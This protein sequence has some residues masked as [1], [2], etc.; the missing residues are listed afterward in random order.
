MKNGRDT[1]ACQGALIW[2]GQDVQAGAG[3][4]ILDHLGQP[5][6]V[7]HALKRVLA[8]RALSFS[9]EA[10]NGLFLHAHNET[11]VRAVGRLQL[12][13][14]R[15]DGSRVDGGELP[16]AV[17]PWS[18]VGIPMEDAFEW[19]L[20]LSWAYR[21]GAP[22]APVIEAIWVDEADNVMA[23]HVGLPAGLN[24][25]GQ[26]DLGWHIEAT[27]P[28]ASGEVVLTVSTR[29]F[30]QSV[31]VDAPGWT[32]SDQAFHLLPERPQR[33]TLRPLGGERATRVELRALNTRRGVGIDLPVAA[34]EVSA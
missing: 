14:F 12:T 22:G 33:L 17:E 25:P 32:A 4:G 24:L 18:S 9:N 16:L 31:L 2:F 10:G 3:F 13:L 23:R 21:F 20:D 28:D 7:F 8:A 26:E 19:F 15:A 30:A 6:A 29:G 34:R 1:S 5:K 11:S 27:P